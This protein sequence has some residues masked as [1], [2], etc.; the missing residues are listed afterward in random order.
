MKI[1]IITINYNNKLGLEKTIESVNSQTFL[2]YEY[3]IIDGGSTDGS[4]SVIKEYSDNINYW[5]SEPDKGIYDAMNKGIVS[6]KGEFICFLNSGDIYSGSYALEVMMNAIKNSDAKLFFGNFIFVNSTDNT[7]RLFKIKKIKY[8]SDLLTNSFGHPATFYSSQLFEEVGLFNTSNKIVSDVEWYLKALIVN[9]VS[10]L[11][12]DY[13]PS[14]FFDGGISTT[15]LGLVSNEYKK[16]I[17][18]FFTN[19]EFQLYSGRTFKTIMSMP[20]FKHM[21][22]KMF[23]LKLKFEDK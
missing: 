2:D 14:I 22:V 20:F 4:V 12:I 19:F 10:F 16:M 11:Q 7:A 8:K 21:V 9:Q 13:S 6:A 5:V 1:S 3:I 15:S 23:N 18:K 17:E